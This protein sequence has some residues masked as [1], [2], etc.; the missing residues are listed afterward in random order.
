MITLE[1]GKKI[2]GDTAK[3]MSDE[4]IIKTGD[5]MYQL[6]D[7]I[8]DTYLAKSPKQR[9]EFVKRANKSKPQLEQKP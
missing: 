5:T 8:I 9:R 2:L 1:K 6:A 4:Q 7:L 3:N